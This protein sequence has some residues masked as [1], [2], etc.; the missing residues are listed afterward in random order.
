MKFLVIV[1]GVVLQILFMVFF[2]TQAISQCAM[3]KV[4]AQ[5]ASSDENGSYNAGILYLM[6]FPYILFGLLGFFWFKQSR[7]NRDKKEALE[8]KIKKHLPTYT[9]N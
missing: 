1:R 9:S 5:Q 7:M 3:C 6:A 4:A 2:I 8:N